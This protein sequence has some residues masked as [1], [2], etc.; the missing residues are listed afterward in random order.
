MEAEKSR[1][2]LGPFLV[3]WSGQLVSMIGSGLTTFALG[4]WVFQRTGSVTRFALISLFAMLPGILAAPAAG[5]YTDR[6]NRAT[7]M[8]LADLMAGIGSLFLAALLFT[9]N[10]QIWLVY[11][12]VSISSV[13]GALRLPAFTAL[14]TL[15]VPK[16]HM[17]RASGMIQVGPAAAQVI[18]PLLAAFLIGSIGLAGVVVID[19][20]TF[21]VAIVSLLLASPR[22]ASTAA[23]KPAVRKSVWHEAIFGWQYIRTR[24]GL[25]Q[26]LILFALTNVTFGFALVL[27]TPMILSFSD[28]KTLGAIMSTGAIGFLAGSI[29]MSVWGGPQRKVNGVLGFVLL[30]GAGLILGGLHGSP[31]VITLG[32]FIVVLAIPI[33]NGSSQ[34]IWMSKTAPEVLGRVFAIRMIVAWSAAPIA[35]LLAGPLADHVFEPLLA[36]H[37]PLAGTFVA[38]IGTGPG[39]GDALMLILCGLLAIAIGA[40]GYMNRELRDVEA[41]PEIIR[42]ESAAAAG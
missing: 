38:A 1:S 8:I 19:L 28:T 41:S 3:I 32:I 31:A 24:S 34:A 35:F 30:Y 17:G 22:V 11:V 23:P 36:A 5:V 26:L 4:I 10:L 25:F 13:T 12:V 21:G 18:S 14:T 33:I 9:G 6:W 37:G 39:R 27:Y 40:A 20:G 29:L 15:L 7:A 42:G 16:Q 2:G